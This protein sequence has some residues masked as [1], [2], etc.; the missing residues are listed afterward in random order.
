M[1]MNKWVLHHVS[2]S[3]GY[4]LAEEKTENVHV[5]REHPQQRSLVAIHAAIYAINMYME[6]IYIYKHI[7]LSMCIKLLAKTNIEL[8]FGFT[9]IYNCRGMD[10]HIRDLDTSKN[11]L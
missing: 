4:L 7:S 1:N 5:L 3:T 8:T 2:T 11:S 10:G 6:H 9:E